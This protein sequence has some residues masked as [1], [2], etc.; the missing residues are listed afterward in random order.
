MTR[1]RLKP[2]ATEPFRP[3]RRACIGWA[4][5]GLA[6]PWLLA[7]GGGSNGGAV[8]S[9]A[10]APTP[11]AEP[12]SVRWCRE[13]IQA[14]LS[15]SESDTTAVSVALLA[16][17]QVV[18]REAF[19]YADR[20]RGVPAT[21]DIRFN[22]GSVSKVVTA[23]AVMVLRDRGQLA[24]DQPLVE[25][26]PDF[27]MLSPGVAQVTPRQLVSHTSGFPGN[28]MR[29]NAMFVPYLDYAQ[30]TMQA[31]SQSHLKHDPGELAVYCNDGFTMVEPLV[32]ALTGLPFYEFVRREIFIP[33]EMTLSDFPVTPAAEGTFVHPYF[34]G[35]S[36]S[37]EM[38]T[39][40]GAGGILSTPTDMLKLAQMFLDQGVYRGRRIVSSDAVREMGVDQSARTL[41]NPSGSSALWGLG[42]DSVQ[43]P[44]MK[45]AGLRAWVKNGETFFF[46]S[47]FFVLP[48]A[49]LAVM[50]TGRGHDY[51]PRALAEGLLLRV[52]AERGAIAVPPPAIVSTAPPIA[53]ASPDRTDLTGVYGNSIAPLQVL[54]A[55]DGSLTLQRWSKDKRQWD[56]ANQQQLRARSDGN[57][58]EDG[59][60]AACYRFQTVLGHRYLIN[61]TLSANALYWAETPMGEWLAPKS[62]LSAAWQAR[63][64]TQWRYVSDSPD[65]LVSR[66]LPP[67]IW[68]IDALPELPGYILFDNEQLL[69]VVSDNEAGM[70]VKVPGNDG[71]DLLE[72]RMVTVNGQEEMHVGGNL[73]FQRAAAA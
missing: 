42:W 46:G 64:G 71:R 18:W 62:P 43:Q 5:A 57:W 38:S 11:Q 25:L 36:L 31:L 67:V 10:A 48:E 50:I 51:A 56:I 1:A 29:N 44:S 45:A 28:N 24:L 32:Y 52:A 17:D 6:A 35:R 69:S 2:D 13:A 47:D 59:Q 21:P 55:A 19:G 3:S 39:P 53:A 70:A 54:S 34:E 60:S 7:C 40:F 22:I 20:E 8:T 23:L 16:D 68:P 73:V 63:L 26:L 14:S 58:W 33:L 49:R 12:E 41:I 30:D 37:Q 9:A 15:R 27:R 66:L 72:L 65:S 4:T 61:R